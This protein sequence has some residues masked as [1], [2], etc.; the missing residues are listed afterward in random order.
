MR[1][2]MVGTGSIGRR[3]MASLRSLVPNVEFDVLRESGRSRE[4]SELG[5]VDVV[6]TMDEALA[7]QPHMMV[8]ANPSSMHLRPLL[9]AI[10]SRIPFYAEKPVVSNLD[11]LTILKSRMASCSLPPNVVGCNLRFLPS[12][13]AFKALIDEGR[14]GRIV[15]ADFEA[16]Q[17][18]PDWRPDQDYRMS[19]SA[20]RTQGGGVLLDLIHEVDAALWLLGDFEHVDGYAVHASSLEIDSDDCAGILMARAGGPIISVRVDYVSRKPIRKYTVVGDRATATW[21][22]RAS[23]IILDDMNGSHSIQLAANAFDVST[24]YPSAMQ[25]LLDAIKLNRPSA[26]PLEEGVRA[27]MTV[28]RAR[29]I[30]S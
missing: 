3:H 11:D 24:T 19:Y 23:T 1:V 2:L 16:G 17:W 12:L 22:L 9:A 18:L 30:Y 13:I 28:L 6:G 8:I 14:L 21:D 20:H 15:R 29:Q 7:R 27:L 25:D 4:T 10:D 5:R 26:Q